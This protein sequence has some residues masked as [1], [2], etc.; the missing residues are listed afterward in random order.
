[1]AARRL[2]RRRCLLRSQRLHDHVA[3]C[4]SSGNTS[5]RSTCRR[6]WVTPGAAAFPAARLVVAACSPCSWGDLPSRRSGATRMDAHRALFYFGQLALDRRRTSPTS[7]VMGPPSPPQPPLVARGGGAVLHRLAARARAAASCCSAAACW[8]CYR[9]ARGSRL[10]AWM[11]WC[12]TRIASAIRRDSTTAPIRARSCSWSGI[13]LA[14]RLLGLV[15]RRSGGARPLARLARDRAVA[16]HRRSAVFFTCRRSCDPTLSRR[17]SLLRSA[18]SV[19]IAA[20]VIRRIVSARHSA[21]RPLRWI[22]ERSYGIYL[23]HWPIVALTRRRVDVS[24]TGATGIIIAQAALTIAAAA[25]S[26]RFVEQPIRTGR[27]RRG[28]PGRARRRMEVLAAGRSRSSV[29]SPSSSSR[30][31]RRAPRRRAAAAAPPPSAKKHRTASTRSR[32][33]STSTNSRPGACS[34]SATR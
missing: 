29:R 14:L 20:V 2:P 4:S 1:M 18:S 24:W 13:A 26:F 30:R 8:V 19:L 15:R 9:T 12:S 3:R 31:A 5:A 34:R 27:C 28:S 11:M 10:G 21:L 23:W 7:T 17:H 6:F 33:R 25:L 32:R 22:G 16:R